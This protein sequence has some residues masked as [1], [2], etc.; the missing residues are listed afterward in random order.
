MAGKS[1]FPSLV[2]STKCDEVHAT[3]T[4]AET[5]A[6]SR[7]HTVYTLLSPNKT[8]STL[9]TERPLPCTPPR[10]ED[11]YFGAED[12]CREDRIPKDFR[13]QA[14]CTDDE[15]RSRGRKSKR[16]AGPLDRSVTVF[17]RSMRDQRDLRDHLYFHLCDTFL[18]WLRE[19]RREQNMGNFQPSINCDLQT[20]YQRNVLSREQPN[21]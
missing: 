18:P 21:A 16:I 1:P 10:Y 8:E 4:A 2:F 3:C 14:P 6:R 5:N 11:P 13:H 9:P 17:G 15:D 20:T 12:R 19:V 7:R